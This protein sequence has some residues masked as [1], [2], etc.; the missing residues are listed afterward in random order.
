MKIAYISLTSFSDCD[1]PLI[2]ELIS[3]GVDITYY[4]IMSDRTKKGGMINIDEVKAS[5]G[6]LPAS[7]YPALANLSPYIDLSKVKVA[8]SSSLCAALNAFSYLSFI[9]NA[10]DGSTLSKLKNS[11]VS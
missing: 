4:M 5:C 8:S 7:E 1:M 10:S 3:Q 6:I 11:I 9:D 2:K